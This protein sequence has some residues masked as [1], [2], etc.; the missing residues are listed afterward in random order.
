[1][2]LAPI[3][4]QTPNNH[5]FST[6]KIDVWQFMN[7]FLPTT[8]S[9]ETISIKILYEKKLSLTENPICSIE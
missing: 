1:M 8:H 3:K 5:N 4:Q 7:D 9:M 2:P 6:H